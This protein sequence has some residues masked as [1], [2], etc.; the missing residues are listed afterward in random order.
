MSLK[1][2]K[3]KLLFLYRKFQTELN[4]LNLS[5]DET[6]GYC[7]KYFWFKILRSQRYFS[8]EN[9]LTV[10]GVRFDKIDN[11][12]KALAVS[13]IFPLTQSSEKE[14]SEVLYKRY[15]IERKMSAAQILGL[16]SNHESAKY[17]IW[18]LVYPWDF[19][20][21]N[22]RFKRYPNALMQNRST[23]GLHFDSS[24]H[25]YFIQQS[26]TLGAAKNQAQQYIKLLKNI[27]ENGYIN[28]NNL[29]QVLI[30]KKGSRWKWMM[31]VEGNHRAY[32]NHFFKKPS[33]YAEVTYIVDI[34]KASKWK[35][36]RNGH[37]SLDEARYIFNQI[38]E[39]EVC[40]RGLI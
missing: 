3:N 27:Q 35:N 9:G 33:L 13:K 7:G 30:L 16:D 5:E 40:F 20:S 32:L 25:K 15:V 36:V 19:E 31:D 21:I 1:F 4:F 37:Y 14:F 26:Y 23:H 2:F 12:P 22:T 10:R 34:S 8:Y 28:D 18:A 6:K 11:D 39:G 17:P 29:P 38:F 24:D